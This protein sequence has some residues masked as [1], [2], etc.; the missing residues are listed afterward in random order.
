LM[1]PKSINDTLVCV[2]IPSYSSALIKII[3]VRCEIAYILMRP[4]SINST[5]VCVAIPPYS[6]ALIKIICVR[7][8]SLQLVEIPHKGDLI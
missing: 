7:C 5:L 1:R 6:Y 2:V 3:C 8:E 4:K